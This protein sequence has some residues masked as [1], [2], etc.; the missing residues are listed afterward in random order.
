MTKPLFLV[1]VDGSECSMRATERAIHLAE[2]V[3]A[4]VTLLSVI[5]WSNQSLVF[6]AD[7]APPEL[8]REAQECNTMNK[9][10]TPLLEKYHDSK[11]D[12]NTKLLFGNPADVI[13]KQVKEMHAKMLFVGRRGRSRLVDMLMGSVA[14]KLA[15]RVGVPIVLVP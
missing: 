1:A 8:D 15:H 12:I 14:S 4:T 2:H 5:Y 3:N 9:V 10:L 7:V 11:V 6:E 13:Q